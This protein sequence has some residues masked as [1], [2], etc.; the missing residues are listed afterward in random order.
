MPARKTL[1]G[2][3]MAALATLAS[4][5]GCATGHDGPPS[6]HFDGR[7]FRNGDP[8]PPGAFWKF[9]RWQL[10]E[11]GIAWPAHVP[12][13]R[14]LPPARV[15]G[16]GPRVSYVGHATVLVQVAGNCGTRAKDV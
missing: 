8:P 6:D 9:L 2:T 15:H 12:I 1:I 14:D 5:A 7:V 11:P 13:E 10:F 3:A 16:S 4:L